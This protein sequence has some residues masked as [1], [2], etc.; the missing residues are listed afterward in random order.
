MYGPPASVPSL[1]VDDCTTLHFC[2]TTVIRPPGI[3]CSETPK[4]PTRPNEELTD[5]SKLS[6]VA[7]N[8]LGTFHFGSMTARNAAVL[9]IQEHIVFIC[10]EMGLCAMHIGR[11]VPQL[12]F[13]ATAIE[14]YATSPC[15]AR[16][17]HDR[18]ESTVLARPEPTA[19][20]QDSLLAKILQPPPASCEVEHHVR[21]ALNPNKMENTYPE[22][23]R[24]MTFSSTFLRA[25]I[26]KAPAEGGQAEPR[27]QDGV[28]LHC[29]T[30]PCNTR[31]HATAVWRRRAIAPAQR[32]DSSP[33]ASV[34]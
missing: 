1:L 20:V 2:P 17:S 10:M 7:Q 9:Q 29:S 30:G 25:A 8:I 34:I 32:A 21:S 24:M 15:V 31:R 33:N 4:K 28:S 16:L 27:H 3:H 14:P 23:P 22:S 5:R 12:P 19:Q 18:A 6:H 13:R 11:C 26:V